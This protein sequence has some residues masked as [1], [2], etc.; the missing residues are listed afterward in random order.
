MTPSSATQPIPRPA[1]TP[2]ALLLHHKRKVTELEYVPTVAESLLYEMSEGEIATTQSHLYTKQKDGTFHGT[3]IDIS[4][5]ILRDVEGTFIASTLITGDTITTRGK[6]GKGTLYE[7][8]KKTDDPSSAFKAK[9]IVTPQ[10]REDHN[11]Y[12]VRF[13]LAHDLC[14]QWNGTG[15][16]ACKRFYVSEKYMTGRSATIGSF[17]IAKHTWD[18]VAGNSGMWSFAVAEDEVSLHQLHLYLE[19]IH[20][21][22]S[23]KK[24]RWLQKHEID[25]RHAATFFRDNKLLDEVQESSEETDDD[26]YT[27]VDSTD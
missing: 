7:W 18:P 21:L 24:T 3:P 10:E 26:E 8:T 13:G 20:T 12:A 4:G 6:G 14:I 15:S 25:L 23:H 9:R 16:D 2:R 1:T 19:A 11:K 5:P 22:S 17:G 27:G